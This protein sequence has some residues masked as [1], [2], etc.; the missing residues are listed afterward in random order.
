[1]GYAVSSRSNAKNAASVARA[2]TPF[3]F[4][5]QLPPS[6]AITA[7]EG[8]FFNEFSDSPKLQK[9]ASLR[10]RPQMNPNRL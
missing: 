8:D 4:H 1:M 10:F 5:P 6:G 9:K 3:P 2:M 7:P